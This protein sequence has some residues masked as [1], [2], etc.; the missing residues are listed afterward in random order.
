MAALHPERIR[1]LVILNA[2][3]PAVVSTELARNPRLREALSYVKL[4]RAPDAEARLAA[5]G[6]ARL[7]AVYAELRAAGRWS[8]ADD[9]RAIA[10]WSRS[11]ALTAALNWYRAADF[12]LPDGRAP[13]EA[14]RLPMPALLLWGKDDMALLPDLA[15]AHAGLAAPLT[16]DIV[17]ACGHWPQHQQPALVVE[18]MRR[19]LA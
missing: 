13:I 7:K 4:L 14:T 10:A 18:R 2:P 8:D 19:F 3:H 16:I 5:E 17:E 12:L 6:F 9:A 15:L 11:G 1:R